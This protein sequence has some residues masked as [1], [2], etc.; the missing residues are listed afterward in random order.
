MFEKDPTGGLPTSI[1]LTPGQAEHEARI[2]AAAA[3]LEQAT[4]SVARREA[5]RRL[6]EL[7]L[8]RD[9]EVIATMEAERLRKV[10]APSFVG[11]EKPDP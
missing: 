9:P 6:R 5:W 1:S 7:I 8:A 3:G 2:E 11:L 4:S 10:G